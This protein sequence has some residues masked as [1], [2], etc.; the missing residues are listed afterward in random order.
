MVVAMTTGLYALALYNCYRILGRRLSPGAAMAWILFNLMLP[1]VG[2]P[3]YFLVGEFRIK[4]YERRHKRATRELAGFEQVQQLPPAPDALAC[5]EAVREHYELFN[6][7]FSRF[8][9][10]F[11]PQHGHAE[12]LVD[13]KKTFAAI[14]EAITKAE[15]Y[16]LVQYYILRSDR[17]GLE[18]KRLLIEK[19]KAGVP[20]YLLYDDMGSF[21]L[22][23]EYIKDLRAAGVVVEQFLAIANFKRFFQ[24]NFRNHRKLVL[25]DGKIAFTG[26]LNVGEEYATSRL[27]RYRKKHQLYWR[28]THLQVEGTTVEQMEDVFLEDWYFATGQRLDEQLNKPLTS[29]PGPA[30]L[31]Q[32]PTG[33]T[34]ESLISVMFLLQMITM[35]K[36]RLWIATPYFIPDVTIQRALELAAARGVDVRLLIPRKSDYQLVQWVT[37]SYAEQAHQKGIQVLLYSA[38]FMHQKVILVDDGVAA[39]GTM[40]LDNRAV[41]Y[42][43]ET[44]VVVHDL[45]FAAKVEAMLQDDFLKC[46]YPKIPKQPWLRSLMRLRSNAARLLA[47]ML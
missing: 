17:L 26:G 28:D 24:M 34:D 16:I 5:P 43:F 13:G 4:G 40:N 1:V 21:W 42:N 31:Q 8:G 45:D 35:A 15:H 20:V 9:P 44:M 27:K 41:Y 25:V 7:T 37:M 36:K 6:R 10:T 23:R 2:V 38:G 32:I 19:A 12:L 47:P 14:F 11:R 30:I 3:L 18:L 33:P 22:K 39:V 29:H 46:G